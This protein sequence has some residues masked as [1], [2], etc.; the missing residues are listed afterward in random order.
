MRPEAM[1]H[2]QGAL[3]ESVFIYLE[4]LKEA[5]SLNAPPR[6]LSVGLGCAYNEFLA[7]AYLMATNQNFEH[8]YLESFEGDPILN[9][10]FQSW[11]LSS[12]AQTPVII[13]LC[14]TFDTVLN[15]VG[16]ELNVEPIKIK[17]KIIQLYEKKQLVIRDWLGAETQFT[18]Q[19]SVIFYD[20]FSNQSTPQIWSDDFLTQFLNRAAQPQCVLATYAAT[21]ALNRCLRQAGFVLK[22]QPGFAGKRESTRAVR[23]LPH[24]DPL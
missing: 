12:A 16:R 9:Q 17:K 6:I 10:S 24:S 7:V 4:A 19:F 15:L 21:G 8:F 3:S 1:H 14:K 5:L 11:L 2:R 23:S 20:A 13:E 18:Q 22:T